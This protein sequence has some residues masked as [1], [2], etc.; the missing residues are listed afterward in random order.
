MN[1]RA[2]LNRKNNIQS[3]FL[4]L[5]KHNDTVSIETLWTHIPDIQALE[6]NADK[7]SVRVERR[8]LDIYSNEKDWLIDLEKKVYTKGLWES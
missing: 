5:E 2:M 4:D 3:L 8:W 1:Y 6:L 7:C